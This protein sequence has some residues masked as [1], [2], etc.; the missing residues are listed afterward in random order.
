[1]HSVTSFA[2][3]PCTMSL[4][5][6]SVS[7]AVF[8]QLRCNLSALAYSVMQFICCN[9]PAAKRHLSYKVQAPLQYVISPAICLLSLSA[10]LQYGSS[11]AMS[12]LSRS[13]SAQL[14]CHLKAQL[15]L[16]NSAVR[17]AATSQLGCTRIVQMKLVMPAATL[18][19][20]YSSFVHCPLSCSL[21]A[22][23]CSVSLAVTYD[24]CA[25]PCNSTPISVVTLQEMHERL[26]IFMHDQTVDQ[27]HVMYML[28]QVVMTCDLISQLMK[29]ADS[30]MCHFS[31]S[32]RSAGSTGFI[33]GPPH[34]LEGQ[35]WQSSQ[36]CWL[37]QNG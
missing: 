7:S 5:L 24:S 6:Q 35:F 10:Q 3:Q 17:S 15:Q 19:E 8:R 34:Y 25:L 13:M 11:A 9:R 21:S 18:A 14:S 12:Q 2:A 26:G 33:L 27:L 1:M 20:L 29:S 4:R 16:V 37:C 23:L 22:Q 28:S 32:C 31:I 30:T 36:V